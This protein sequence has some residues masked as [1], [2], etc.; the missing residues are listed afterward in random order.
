MPCSGAVWN[1]TAWLFPLMPLT[2][3]SLFNSYFLSGNKNRKN[4]TCKNIGQFQFCINL[5]PFA[6]I[7]RS[8]PCLKHWN[9]R[10]FGDAAFTIPS[11]KQWDHMSPW[12]P[13]WLSAGIDECCGSANESGHQWFKNSWL[14]TIWHYISKMNS[15]ATFSTIS[16]GAIVRMQI[17]TH[18]LFTEEETFWLPMMRRSGCWGCRSGYFRF[19]LDRQHEP[20][21]H[22]KCYKYSKNYN[23]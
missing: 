4:I 21:G 3:E 13:S 20:K 8:V 23:V 9:L 17:K 16:S 22:G 11:G 19:M 2:T 5:L 10:W 6:L 12:S 18:F 15:G 14:E 7:W 1:H